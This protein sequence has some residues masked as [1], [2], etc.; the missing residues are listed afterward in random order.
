M[1]AVKWRMGDKVYIIAKDRKD[2]ER[3]LEK[4]QRIEIHQDE[5]GFWLFTNRGTKRVAK[6][7]DIKTAKE[8][9]KREIPPKYLEKVKLDKVERLIIERL[10]SLVIRSSTIKLPLFKSMPL[11]QYKKKN[12]YIAGRQGIGK[13]TAIANFV[14]QLFAYRVIGANIYY[15]SFY[16]LSPSEL[17][18]LKSII[19]KNKEGERI[20]LVVIDD[21]NAEI[22]E[23]SPQMASEFIYL[24]SEIDAPKITISNY[25]YSAIEG[26]F[27]KKQLEPWILS[28]ISELRNIEIDFKRVENNPKIQPLLKDKRKVK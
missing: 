18:R 4:D 12:V 22:F 23:K 21:L 6:P 16:H 19:E 1:Y 3:F 10:K 11:Y 5:G 2:L 14:L 8:I 13:T 25:S 27:K 28:R 7:L 26:Y 9:L 17:E 24:L 20:D 15:F